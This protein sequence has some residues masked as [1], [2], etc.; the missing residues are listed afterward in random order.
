M[1]SVYLVDTISYEARGGMAEPFA[2]LEGAMASR[3]WVTEWTYECDA[4][5]GRETWTQ[6][7]RK[8]VQDVEEIQLVEIGP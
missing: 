4:E 3:P 2:T 7:G 1:A 6:S 5:T 8:S